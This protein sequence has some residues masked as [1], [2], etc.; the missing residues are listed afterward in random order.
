MLWRYSVLGIYILFACGDSPAK[1][2]AIL[3]PTIGSVCCFAAHDRAQHRS[4]LVHDDHIILDPREAVQRPIR[5]DLVV[6]PEEQPPAVREKGAF[7]V[8]ADL[9]AGAELSVPPYGIR[10][11]AA[12][13][14]LVCDGHWVPE[15]CR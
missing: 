8:V 11:I 14:A 12:I 9:A 2:N 1:K 7:P 3:C 6:I 5:D 10:A 4:Y 15:V 13:Q